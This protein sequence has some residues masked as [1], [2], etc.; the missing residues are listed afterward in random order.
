MFK[1][2]FLTNLSDSFA[3][4]SGAGIPNY[5]A[6]GSVRWEAGGSGIAGYKF[7]QSTGTLAFAIG[8]FLCYT[9]AAEALVD[10]TNSAFPAGVAQFANATAGALLGWVQFSGL[11]TLNTAYSTAP[12]AG[13]KVTSSGASNKTLKVAAAVTDANVGIAT[14]A[15]TGV[16]LQLSA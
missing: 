13:N 9:A 15:T 10:G 14:S 3:V 8:D 2:Q 5:D 12:A 16:H 11:A 1:Q 7:V 6:V 4:F